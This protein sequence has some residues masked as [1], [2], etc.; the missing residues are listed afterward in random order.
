MDVGPVSP[1]PWDDGDKLMVRLYLLTDVTCAGETVP[2]AA[3]PVHGE[4]RV[5]DSM[6]GDMNAEPRPAVDCEAD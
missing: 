2:F 6:F 5:V 4:F 3:L 1:Q